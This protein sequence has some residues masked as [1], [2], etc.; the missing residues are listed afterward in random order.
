MGNRLK[1]CKDSS[2]VHC[3]IGKS[4]V[5]IIEYNIRTHPYALLAVIFF[6]LSR[7]IS[8]IKDKLR[9]VHES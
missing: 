5:Q 1:K 6:A 3:C 2:I 8:L 9:L 4:T 7:H